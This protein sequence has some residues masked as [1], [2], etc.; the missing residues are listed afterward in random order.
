MTRPAVLG[1]S[2]VLAMLTACAAAAQ[3]P[4]SREAAIE[5]AQNAKAAALKPA[6]LGKA[7]QYVARLSDVF[8]TGL[9]VHPYWQSAYSGGGFTLGAGY[10][11]HVSS[12]NTVD[13][14]GSITFS[15]YKRIEAEFLAPELFARR[16]RLSV[17]GGWR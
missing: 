10:L 9:T 11:K 15:G 12:Y 16:A 13:L 8:L 7:E 17:L 14:R 2:V 3:E 5:Q 4:A 6:E 1:V